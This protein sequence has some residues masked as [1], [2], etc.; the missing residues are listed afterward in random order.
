[1]NLEEEKLSDAERHVGDMLLFV[2]TC[3]HLLI[4]SV[5]VLH[6]LEPWILRVLT[7][8]R[9]RLL[10]CDGNGRLRSD[11]ES[12]HAWPWPMQLHDAGGE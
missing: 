10:T 2:V 5:V 3:P 12:L 7:G 6:P 9:L 4:F 1:M 8:R 11:A